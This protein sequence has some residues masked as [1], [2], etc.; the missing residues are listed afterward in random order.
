M[1]A[2]PVS[3]TSVRAGGTASAQLWIAVAAGHHVQANPAAKDML[4]P[5]TVSFPASDQL[6]IVP[7]YPAPQQYKLQGADWDLLTY[8][9]RFPVLLEVRAAAGARAGVV[10]LDGTV[11]YQACNE[12]ACLPPATVPVQ[13]TAQIESGI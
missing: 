12:T 2:E 8:E 6:A 1:R 3:V 5:L 4:R 13:L 10:R 11:A 9:G 7:T